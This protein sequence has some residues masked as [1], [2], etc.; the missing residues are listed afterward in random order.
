MSRP[1]SELPAFIDGLFTDVRD[2]LFETASRVKDR[3]VEGKPIRYP[4]QWD[5][6]RQQ[7]AYF[8]TNGFGQ[9]IPYNRTNRTVLGIKL[10]RVPLG[11]NL[12]LPHPAGAVF[13]LPGTP[14]TWQS[15]IHRS[16]WPYLLEVLF[17]ELSRLP[18]HITNKIRVRGDQ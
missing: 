4:V 16:R 10:E 13:G 8:A 18:E 9:G 11:S 12:R 2:V 14:S 1:I 7:R 3:L 5:S 15:R 17:D 6:P